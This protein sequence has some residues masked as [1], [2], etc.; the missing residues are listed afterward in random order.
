MFDRNSGTT[1][2]EPNAE[3]AIVT[4][5]L[6][7]RFR[8]LVAVADVSMTVL[9]SEIFGLIGPN[10]AGKSTLIKMLT[11]SCHLHPEPRGLPALTSSRRLPMC[12]G[13][14]VMFHSSCLWRIPIQAAVGA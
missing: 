1:I 4:Q 12:A 5:A 13:A 3:P 10:G 14:S 2:L 9:H 7:R 6:A 11:L 8:D